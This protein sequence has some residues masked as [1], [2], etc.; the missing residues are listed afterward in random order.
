MTTLHRRR[1]LQALLASLPLIASRSWAEDEVRAQAETPARLATAWR[2]PGATDAHAGYRAGVL[3]LDW[4]AGRMRLHSEIELP[5]RAHGL[6]ALPDGGYVV[7]ANRPGRWLLRCDAAGRVVVRHDIDAEQPQ[8][9][10]NG[11]VVA[12]PDGRRLLT[13]ETDVASGEG[14]IGVRDPATL[15]RVGAYPS[16]GLD[17]HQLV[18]DVD[19]ALLVANGGIPRD[20]AGRKVDL[21]RMAPSLVRLAAD[22]GRLLG[23]WELPDRRLSLRHMAWA[24]GAQPL[25]GLALQAEH[26]DAGERAQAPVLAV[27]DGRTLAMPNAD[28]QGGG[29]AG[30]IAAAPG[31]GFVL[32]AQKRRLGLWWH[33]GRPAEMTRIAELTEP[34]ALVDTA[35]GD[36]VHLGAGRGIARW[37]L[38]LAPRMLPWPQALAP[39]NHAVRL[40]PA[41]AT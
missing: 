8:R 22:G 3:E 40:L 28:A 5:S 25:L 31:G 2:L 23:R 27:W 1:A 41:A 20:G 38:R 34:C 16:L 37:H 12:S 36:G 7:V 9:S 6:L 26:D 18:F 4:V 35:D 10:F 30:D 19:G 32:S 11:H 39:D 29:Y 15:A 13:V 24:H 21:E 33:P 14:W 17:P